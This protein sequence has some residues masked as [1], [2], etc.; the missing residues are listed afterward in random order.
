MPVHEMTG[1]CLEDVYFMQW[2][3][4]EQTL[5]MY[6]VCFKHKVGSGKNI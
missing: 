3:A 1:R 4:S 2:C 6:F 5:L